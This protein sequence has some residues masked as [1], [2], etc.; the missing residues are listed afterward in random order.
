MPWL[1]RLINQRR[2]FTLNTLFDLGFQLSFAAMIA[3]I[4]GA[5]WL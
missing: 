5:A 2:G 4:D 1:S 3:G